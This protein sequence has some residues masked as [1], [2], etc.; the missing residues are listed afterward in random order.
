MM[1]WFLFIWIM[2]FFMLFLLM[3][4]LMFMFM[5]II[6]IKSLLLLFIYN[7]LFANISL[8]LNRWN[9]WGHVCNHSRLLLPDL[10]NDNIF[11]MDFNC[12]LIIY[13]FDCIACYMRLLLNCINMM[14][15]WLLVVNMLF[16]H[17]LLMS[18]IRIN[19]HHLT[20]LF[21][22]HLGRCLTL[23]LL[24]IVHNMGSHLNI[25]VQIAILSKLTSVLS[26]SWS[27]RSPYIMNWRL[28]FRE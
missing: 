12:S 9:I 16:L 17:M 24:I 25:T 10:G 15:M 21:S 6:M 26:I 5:S 14:F 2:N 3:V 7:N 4:L 28:K 27:H 11:R 19:G 22:Y 8:L 13:I 20:Q 18:L 1:L 23:H